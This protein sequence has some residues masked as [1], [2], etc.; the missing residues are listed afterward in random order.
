M[1]LVLDRT[2]SLSWLLAV[3]FWLREAAV[4]SEQGSISFIKQDTYLLVEEGFPPLLTGFGK[5]LLVR[6]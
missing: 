2:G 5:S 3:N 6:T 1:F 4:A